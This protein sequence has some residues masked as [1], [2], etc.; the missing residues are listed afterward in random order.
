M[1]WVYAICDART[2]R[3]GRDKQ[4]RNIRMQGTLVEQAK[5]LL[6]KLPCFSED[7]DS[8]EDQ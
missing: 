2:W 5:Q 1:E 7:D 4:Q 3:R 6:R 8:G